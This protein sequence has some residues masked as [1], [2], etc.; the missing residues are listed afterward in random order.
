MAKNNHSFPSQNNTNFLTEKTQ[1]N[2]YKKLQISRTMEWLKIPE[3]TQKNFLKNFIHIDVDYMQYTCYN[4]KTPL[5]LIYNILGFSGKIDQDN[6]NVEYNYNLN[7]SL[8]HV[9][10]RM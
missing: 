4:I 1:E 10:T 3:K 8:T 7:L 2:R 5:E 6:S 9:E